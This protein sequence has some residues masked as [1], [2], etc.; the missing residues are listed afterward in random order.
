MSTFLTISLFFLSASFQKVYAQDSVLQ[1]AGGDTA[2]S[3]CDGESATLEV[4]IGTSIS[5]YTI[6]Y[7]DGSNNYTV[8]NYRSDADPESP[9]YGGDP[10]IVS[11]SVTTTYSLVSVTDQYNTSLPIS[12][13]TVSITVNPLP[14]NIVATVNG[15]APVCYGIAFDISA[16]ATKGNTYELWNAA[17]TAKLA[18]L[19]YNTTI[20]AAANYTIRAIS[21]FGCSSSQSLTVNLE[22]T[23]SAISGEGDKILNPLAGTCS[24]LLPDYTSTVIV[25]D[26]CT[27]VGNITLT[28]NPVAG[29]TISDHN[30]VQPIEIIATDESGNQSTYNFN[31]TLIDTIAPEI[32]C[33]IDQNNVPANSGCSYVHSGAAW[34]AV[35]TDNCSVT[36]VSYELSGATSGSGTTLNG[37]TFL[38]GITTVTWTVTDV[39][40]LTASCSF[41]V[42][43]SDSEAPTV[44]CAANQT[45]NTS[46]GCTYT[47]VGTSWDASATDNC[48][49]PSISYVLSGDTT[50]TI[51][52]TLDGAVFNKGV[53][54]VTVTASDTAL[55]TG[56]CSFTVTINDNED[57]VIVNLPSNIS[58]NNDIDSCGAVVT[59]TEPTA[60]DNCTLQSLTYES[61][62]T[63][64]LTLGDAFPIGTTIITYTA[65][66]DT[67]NSA[68]GSFNVTVTDSQS[69]EITCP[70]N[71]SQNV[72]AGTCGA[73]VTYTAP[74]GTD[75]CIGA[76]TTQIA[77]LA[78]GSIFPVGVTTNTFQ[79]VDASGN[80]T[81]CSFTVTIIDN[82]V[83]VIV[84]C[85]SDI[86]QNNDLNLCSAVVSWT[87][88]TATDNCTA[89]GVITWTKSHTPGSVFPVGTTEVTYVAIDASG[90]ESASCT[91]NVTVNDKQL[92]EIVACPAN[93]TKSTDLG[94]CEATVS[95]TEPSANDNCTATGDLVWVK[96]H[97]PGSVFAPGTTTVTY[98]AQD[99]AGNVSLACSFDVTV[100]DNRKP[101]INNCPSNIIQSTDAN[102]CF[103]TVTWTEPTATD[104]CTAQGD[105]VWTK[106][107]NPGDTFNVGTT[108]VTYTATD[109]NGNISNACSF[110]VIVSDTE[111]PIAICAS[112]TISLNPSGVATLAAANVDSGSS[113]NCT[114]SNSLIITLSKT[115]FNCTNIGENLVTMSVK[116]ASGNISTCIATVTVVDPF[117][118]TLTATAGTVDSDLNTDIG[119][120]YYQVKGSELD[121]IAS[122]NCTSGVTLSYTVTGATTLSGTG[123]MAGQNLLQGVN[124]ITWTASDGSNTSIP[125]V[126]TKTVID[127]RAPSLLTVGNQNKGTTIGQCGYLV[128]GTE[129]DATY[130]DNC[131]I[132]S[133]TYTI[134]GGT[135]VIASTLDGVLIAPGINTLVWT[136]SDGTN[137][138]SA[139]FRVTVTDTTLPTITPISDITE[140]IS[141]GCD[142]V[143]TW[144]EPTASDNC[145][146]TSFT[147]TAGLASGSNFPVG[148]TKITYTA[149]DSSGNIAKM[150]FNVSV[151]DLTP[152]VL[153][154]PSGSSELAPFERNADSG[155]CFYTVQS[156]EFDATTTDGCAFTAATNSFDGTTTLEGKELPVGNNVITWT[157]VDEFNNTSS[158]TIYVRVLDA[159]NPTFDQPTGN[160]ALS[161][162]YDRNANPAQCFYTISDTFFDLRNISDNCDLQVPTYVITK[163]GSTVFTG[164][165]SLSGVELPTDEV[166][167]YE[168]VWTVQDVNGNT[169][170]ADMFTISVTDNQAPTF[171]CYGNEIRNIPGT[172]CNYTISGTEFDPKLLSDNCDDSGSLTVSYTLDGVSGGASTTLAGVVLS[173]GVHS[174]VWTITDTK[175]NA[176]TCSFNISVKDS[177]LPTL[178]TVLDQTRNAPS[179]SCSYTAIGAEFDPVTV[180]DNCPTYTLVNN[181][182][183]T[184]TLAGFEF[185]VGITVVVWTVTDAGG[186]VA[187]MQ[188]QVEVLD[189]TAPDYEIIA[190]ASSNVSVTKSTSSTSCFYTVSGSEFDPQA[191]TDNCTANNYTI[192]NDYNNYRSLAFEQFPV[193][194]TT[195]NWSV[196]DNYGNETIKTL[197]ITVVDDVSPVISCPSSAYT[198]VYGQGQNYYTVGNNEFKPIVYDN[199][200]ISTYTYSL[201]GATTGSGTNLTGVQLNEGVNTIVWTASDTA[202]PANTQTCSITVN[203][204]SDLYPAITCV[205]DQSKSTDLG[206]CTYTVSGTEFNA[207]STTA[208][209]TLT[210]NFN[211]S[212]TLAGAIFPQG[213]TLV[214]WTASQTV[215]GTVYTND[216]S[217]YVFVNDIEDPQITAPA[218]ITVNTNSGCYATGVNLG[219][220]IT[221][222]NC[223][224][225][226]DVWN[227][228]VDLIFGIGT[229]TVT[230]YAE[231]VHGNIA[232]ATQTVTVVDDDA[233]TFNCIGSICREVDEGQNYY[234]VFDHEFN[235]YNVYDCSTITRTNDYNNGSTLAGEQFPVGVTV[236]TWTFTDANSNVSTCSTTVTINNDD[237]PSVTC[238][239]YQT[240]TTDLDVCTYTISGNELDISSTTP[241][242]TLTYELT[243]ATTGTGSTTLDGIVLN[244]G[245]TTVSWTATNGADSN[246]CCTYNIR[247]YDNQD[248]I[249]SWP[250]D[251]TV[252]VD[253][254]SCNATNVIV[255]TPTATDNCDNSVDITYTKSTNA[256]TF[257][258][259]VTNV[260]WTAR[261]T[262]GNYVSHTQV[263]TVTDDIAP[264]IVC[265]TETYYREYSNPYVDYYYV[266]GDEFT[267]TVSDNCSLASYVNSITGT[268][269]INGRLL[270]LGDHTITWTATDNN[271]GTPNTATCDVNVTIVDSFDPI[272]SCPENISQNSDSGD[273]SYTVPEG[274]TTYDATFV[275]VSGDNRTMTH[276]LAGAPSNTTLEGATIPAGTNTITWTATQEIGGTTY[277]SSCS[278][279]F[280][281]LDREAPVLDLPFDDVTVNVD[282]GTCTNTFTLTPPTATDNCSAP[283]DIT[284]ISNAPATF[285]LGT[286]N[287]RW[288]L[289][290][291]AGNTTVYNQQV[292]VYD[293]EAPV[294]SNCPATDLTAQ[295]TGSLCQVVVSWPAL[296]ATDD[297]SG[298]KSFT[299]THSPGTLFGV[300]TTTVTYT[301]IDNNDNES[302]CSF[303]VVVTDAVPTIACVEDQ[304]RSADAGTCS[305]KV[306][307]NEFDPITY[308][309]NCE[310]PTISWSFTHPETLELVTGNN[311][312]SGVSIPRGSDNGPTTGQIAITWTATDS[313]SQTASCTFVLTITDNEPPILVVPGNQ[314][315]S[316]D[317]NQNYYTVSGGEF[318]DVTATD[319]C[320]IVT[321]IVNEFDIPSLDGLQLQ[322]GENTIVWKATDDSGNLGSATFY[323]YIE[324]TEL[325]RLENAPTG[326]SA[327]ATGCSAVVNYTA[328]TFIDNATSQA[329]LSITVSPAY[330]VSG[331]DFPVG[332]TPVTYIVSDEYG[333]VFNYS[334]DVTVTDNIDPTI[335][336]PAG[337]SG[338]QLIR[339]TDTGEAFYT[340]SGTE[341]DPTSFSDNC[342]VTLENNYNNSGTLLGETFPVGTTD[343]VWTVTDDSGN[344]TSCTIQVIVT[345]IEDPV[346]NSCADATVSRDADV[347]SCF[348]TVTSSEFDPYDFN[349]NAGVSKLT[350]SID[351]AAEVGTDINTTLVGAQIPVGTL[352]NPTTTVLWR[353]YDLSNNVSATCE[354][355]FTITD[356]ELPQVQTIATQTRNLNT[357]LGTYTANISTDAS[358]DLTISDN[359]TLETI[360]YQI[361]GGDVVGTDTNTSIIGETFTA[362]THTVI[363]Q[364]TDIYGNANSGSYQVII[365]D[366]EPPTAVCNNITVQLDN[367]G[368]YSLSSTDIDNIALGS[369]DPS[370]I[371]TTEVSPSSFDCIDVGANAV[372]VTLTDN[373]GN[374][375][376]CEATVTVEDNIPPTA[377]CKPV[378]LYIDESGTATITA[379]S[380]NNGSSDICGI[381]SISASKTVFNCNDFGDNTVT[382]TVTD[383]NGNSSTCDTTVTILDDVQPVAVCKNIT[384]S[385]DANGIATISGLDVDNGSYDNC[386]SNELIRTATPSTFNCLDIGE[387]EV[388]LTVADPAGNEDTCTAIVTVV[389]TVA[390][391][392]VCQNITVQLDENGDAI[393]SANDIDNGSFDACGLL[394]LTINKTNFDC[395]NIGSNPVTNT[396]TLTGI[397]LYGNSASCS[398]L[399]TVEDNVAPTITCTTDQVV[400]TDNNI[401]SYT[402]SNT[403]WDAIANDA[404]GAVSSLTYALSGATV[405]ADAPSNTSLNGQLF[406]PGITT[407]TW[408]A[409]D[410]DSNT[411]QCSY[412]VT[413]NDNQLPNAICQ[414]ITV[415]LDASGNASI[416]AGDI[417]NGSNDNCGIQSIVASKTDFTCADFGANTVTL[418]VTDT[419]NNV[420][421]C[422]AIVTVEDNIDPVAACT[423]IT[424]QLNASGTYTLIASDI[425]AIS[426]GSSDNC[427]IVTR[428][429]FPNT[430]TCANTTT[431]VDVTLTVT[432]IAGNTDTCTTTVTVENNILPTAI[433]KDI[434]V[435]LNALGNAT[436]T[437][438]DIDNNSTD[439][440]A[441]ATRV[442]SKTAFTCA[443]LGLN[444][445]TLTITDVNGNVSTCNANVTIVD[446]IPPSFTLVSANQTQNTNTGVCTYTKTDTNWDQ[447]ATDNCDI[448][449]VQY[450]LTGA[451]TGTGSSLD[452]VAFNKGVT[453]LIWTATDASGNSVTTPEYTITVTDIEPPVAIAQT[454]NAELLR[455]G[456]VIVLPSEINNASTDN[457][458]IITY[459]ISRDNINF[460]PEA[461]FTCIDIGS[462]TVYLRVTD[463][464]GNTH[465]ESTSVTV[466]DTQA[467]T[468]DDLSDRNEIVDADVCT[469][470]HADTSWDPTDN[471]DL[472]PTITYT[473]SGA[474]TVVTAP[475]TTLNGQVFE[476]GAT[477]VTWTVADH[478]SPVNSGTVTFN[479]IVTDTQNPTISCPANIVQDVAS[480]GDLSVVVSGITAPTYAD[481]C[482]VTQITYELSG[483]TT[484]A[485]QA[486]GI[487]EL[488]SDTFNLG[489]TTVT[490]IAY[491]EAGNTETCNFTITV[492][493]LANNTIIVSETDITTSEDL[494]SDTFTV[495]L[496]FAPTGTVVFDVV[497]SDTTEATVNKSQLTFNASNWDTPQVV[498]VTGVNDDVD[499]D[500]ISYI[501]EL[502]T[503]QGL[504]DDLSGYENVDPADVNAINQDNDTAGVTVS[505]ISGPTTEAGGTATFTVVLDTEPTE[506]VTITLSSDDTTESDTFGPTTLTFTAANWN[507]PQTVTVTGKDDDIV[508]GN[509]TYNIVTSNASSTDPKYDGLVVDDVSIVNNDNDTTGFIVTPTTLTTSEAGTSATFTIVLTSKPGTDLDLTQEVV[510]DVAS[511]NTNE[512]T[513][514]LSQLTFTSANWD[515]P[516]TITVTGVDESIVDGTIAYTIENTV[517]AASTTDPNYDP[518]NPADVAVNNTD[519]DA[520]F[521]SIDSVTQVE[522]NTGTT[523]FVFTITHSGDEVAGGYGV[524]FY[525]SNGSA[526]A[527]TDFTGSGGTRNFTTGTIGETQTITIAVNGDTAVERNETF[528]VVL[529]TVIAPGKN[530]TII[531]AGKTGIGTITN[532]DNATLSIADE[533]IVEGDS[534]TKTLTFTVTLDREV[535]DGLSIDYTTAD[536]TAT[537]AN[538]DYVATS[539]TLVFIGT[540][541]ET[542]TIAVTINGDEIVELDETFLVNLSNIVPVSAPGV[543]IS[544]AD[545]SA[546]G[547]ITNDDSAVI[548]IAGFT[549]NEATATANFTITMDKSVQSAFTIDFATS[550]DSALSGSD[551]TGI[552]STL[553]FGGANALTQTVSIP[554]TND[555]FVEPSEDLIGTLSNMVDAANQSITFFGGGASTQ[556]TGTITD[557]DSASIAINDVSVNEA[558]GNATFTVTLTGDIQDDLTVDYTT[559]NIDALAGS[560]YTV[561]SGTLTFVGGS[562]SG[563]T[564]TITVPILNDVIAEP[565]ET[566]NVNLSNLVS[567]GSASISDNQGLGTITDNDPLTLEIAGFTITET[568]ATQTANFVVTSD[569]EAQEDIIVTFTTSNVS[570]TSGSDL[571]SQTTQSYTLTAGATSWNIPVSILGDLVAEPTET[572]TG[573][574]AL[575]NI[576]GQQ[577]TI[578]T[579]TA[580]AT[581]LDNDALE[582][583]LAGFTVTETD[584]TQIQNFVA[585]TNISAQYDIVLSFTTSDGTALDGNDYTTQT[586][587][588]VTIL[589]GSTSVNIPVDILGDLITE[590]QEAF[591]SAITLTNANAQ[592][593]SI[594]TS[595]ATATI[596]D[597]DP[598]TL[599]VSAFT[600]NE[601]AGTADFTITL[602]RNVQNAFTV[603]FATSD[604][605]TAIGNALAGSDYT[606]I[607][608]TTLN[609]GA[610]NP[611][612]QTITITI[613]DD[614][615]VEP[616]ETFIGTL[617]NLV[618]NNQAVTIPTPTATA[619]I[620]DNDAA[621]V[622]IDDITVAEDVASGT[623][624]FTV[625]LTGHIQDALTVDFTTNDGTATNPAVQ[626]S[627]YTLTTG[628]I[629]FP[630]GSNSNTST[631]NT[632]TITV[633]II[634]NLITEPLNEF[635]TVDLSNIISTGTATI[636]DAQGLGTIVD[637]DPLNAITLTGFNVTETNGNVLHNFVATLDYIAQE[638]IIISFT[639]T[640]GTAV[641]TDFTAQTTV[642]Y[643]IP[644]NTLFVNIPVE[645]LGDLVLE[646]QESFTGTI[647]LVED[648][649]QQVTI[650]T[651]T[652]IGVINDDDVAVISIAGFT[653]DE[654]V[655]TAEFT[656]TSSA[657]IQNEVTVIFST[658]NG[659]AVSGSDYTAIASTTLTFGGSNSN[660][661]TVSVS[662]TDDAIAEPT[663]LFTG[664]LSALVNNGQLVTLSDGAITSAIGTITDNDAA[665]LAINS[666]SQVEVDGGSTVDYTFTVTHN[667][668]TTDG[669]FTVNFTTTNAE[670]EAGLD[671]VAQSGTLT[672]SGATGETQT[673][674]IT[675]N[676]DDIL[677]P[678]ETFTVDLAENDFGG[679]DITFTDDSGLGTITDNDA[680]V[681]TIAANDAVA[682]EPSNNGQFTVS[683]GLVSS[684][685]TEVSYVISGTAT[686]TNDYTPL[687]GTVTIPAGSLSAPIDVLVVN[688]NILEDSETVTL[689]LNA[690]TSGDADITIDTNNDE[691][692]VT[693]TDDDASEVSITATDAS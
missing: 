308:D 427:S 131:T 630:A 328:P 373:Y 605:G 449:L 62:P 608:T 284:I 341:F 60:T 635:Y 615:L 173:A 466:D 380:I 548:S 581:I 286:T 481:N 280:T 392:V 251:I 247:V 124:E 422:D 518:L 307:G 521:V 152:P 201:S 558:D 517:N 610:A 567:T 654:G 359:C 304:T 104:N 258:L 182:S 619:T 446:L 23:P 300:G 204:V 461:L 225:V 254:G 138:K 375:S 555:T 16:T 6:I 57:P 528:S 384:V 632:Q 256:T 265:P 494:T 180:T 579:A 172:A 557:N 611:L 348:F 691:A 279:T 636:D 457:C 358:W 674:T 326:I 639:T 362:G 495:V 213:T 597:N 612:I 194:T 447:A 487:N 421:T 141:T 572:F 399:V 643:T 568:E 604:I 658:S 119:V 327:D 233:P 519:N 88:P 526:K 325:P 273:C 623:A 506:D 669:P 410:A 109:A 127:N 350:Y 193:G 442:A 471:C 675:A 343:V 164:S 544:F 340:T 217:L 239:G 223:S 386:I 337:D 430:F 647:A 149:T 44:S 250:A 55:N 618:T 547:T 448:P 470:T 363:W 37:V 61:S 3:I 146:I 438:N 354:T 459:E 655:G 48:G 556:A 220:P 314:T 79:V 469:Y 369:S 219:T 87:E 652:A 56:T 107:H 97:T 249:V 207:T 668:Q 483:A 426:A 165:G 11:P 509:V 24:V 545:D 433:C 76:V 199:C 651:A 98:T 259:G 177:V 336:C 498:T 529:N 423:P 378:T 288:Q 2:I 436:I 489:T 602:S 580:T 631:T 183:G 550:D 395:S 136:V 355:V 431:P 360:T 566:Y 140:E 377:L 332:I 638:P 53:T 13:S 620:N 616:T 685:D 208:G 405:L 289:T 588:V 134:N 416:V 352:A 679:R 158:C 614:D 78:S 112:P 347:G 364:A 480:P 255:G 118:P 92:P 196:K 229:T 99:E 634:D 38:A 30:T 285:L 235:P 452:G 270:T 349:D 656:I 516:Q 450:T 274:V 174:V 218:D 108:T 512:G 34:N 166:N 68:T 231:D 117:A 553:N 310:A 143:V 91:F 21:E 606:A 22:S 126:F 642:E 59:W 330:A 240:R 441:I 116:D 462:N 640:N 311:T 474:T 83:P 153:S 200:G 188:Y 189:I 523:N 179:T 575:S 94:S 105:L 176:A 342:L 203:V 361:D 415:Q 32:T 397:D 293:N 501:V 160:P 12:S 237:P 428:E 106:S 33:V 684:T 338:N 54:T 197:E 123:S 592:Q 562:L 527:P 43:I 100:V 507:T 345:D 633:P 312:L 241:G 226:I 236:V 689:T 626:P 244:R 401:C 657:V 454:V 644:S 344:S 515:T 103:A 456:T 625:T 245:T 368:S 653:E 275:S 677:E 215:D 587:T 365:V 150:S 437:A 297:C 302:T 93:I 444:I 298:V 541:G 440:C 589:A 665:T 63:A 142:A 205:G 514:D 81:S 432:D 565:T 305:Y 385:L 590:P 681:L 460:G 673:I 129:F 19:P 478:S 248:P 70:E 688:D 8:N 451:T 80:T 582:I 281:V 282:P 329:N 404:C 252:S 367:T 242:T 393:I 434:V 17:N 36:T 29:S 331:Y 82:E 692:T 145:A 306:L 96:S 313:N 445:V 497:S 563:S 246:V 132:T 154:C 372:T 648:N 51:A 266:N 549:V 366:N 171:E 292:T 198:R 641:A 482:A 69:P 101:V 267:P 115:S 318:D 686:A 513:V 500:D 276:D 576:N 260:Y 508:D 533:S 122:D 128:S 408:T 693:I 499:D 163:N 58:V 683:L 659:S 272:I 690:I 185:P 402:H 388:T 607:P 73:I 406:N 221:S 622:V 121:P 186:N 680:T 666:I 74:V 398:A 649:D 411:S 578:T 263:I 184:A 230:W 339:N 458:G 95:W 534:G 296:N 394:S 301:A 552:T 667:G 650:G 5:P 670:A 278:F 532:D 624:V 661:Q 594:G 162:N 453:T 50:G 224:G 335:A 429:V 291:E 540:E 417:D 573:T 609:F 4:I 524:S 678:T 621:S 277:T 47:H 168:I 202:T 295:A 376:S 383:V 465:V 31:V 157:A 175:G 464:A 543:A 357:G 419:S 493:A 1:V 169:V 190:D 67:G 42:S 111:L 15:G 346:I 593:V 35:A 475:N 334:F 390:P 676:G 148:I 379:A 214:T 646:P 539:G 40:G 672:F 41:D 412:T 443:D 181:Q 144:T 531:P 671:Y 228:Q 629:T 628:T 268:R 663:E 577:V 371:A 351:G 435:P 110:D 455:D 238:R 9:T 353:L 601:D 476:K 591:T 403:I 206:V 159:Q 85:P 473:L 243:G 261:D 27:S 530:I 538:S 504:T 192:L 537:T 486:S 687:T 492:N 195:V 637:D 72:A 536:A 503:N 323:A 18:D 585:S 505:S 596:N 7:S 559:A 551:Y 316:T 571:T 45:R 156:T 472:A 662:I 468:L 400:S 370:G 315:R 322:I 269:Y 463:E 333:N 660:T 510:V 546:V 320:G 287:V 603:D 496:P 299:S 212:S 502:T 39:A 90:N 14:S 137:N 234:T 424:V 65:T 584:G 569:I 418:T 232:S 381:A 391:T 257:S 71:I 525:T 303:D 178:S 191:I 139:S 420:S 599:A 120:C 382:L 374:I 227:N 161:Y 86:V 387:N 151:V 155:I 317:L 645:V 222:D 407:V 20:T 114:P 522:T 102:S 535:E 595:S 617:S 356:V 75:N 262:R 479:V 253:A 425:D 682:A 491:D 542:K 321:K 130:S 564:L 574:I 319:N 216:C 613:N 167:P 66:D 133:V 210:N 77:G 271:P 598:A 554:I 627:D 125:L 520:A 209:A 511:S 439:N 484:A 10:I 170:I 49:A 324:D 25:S 583:N 490:Y 135:P 211:N 586:A 485:A 664:V 477:T 26:N 389:D 561:T 560:D 283:E 64:G 290:D 409:I 89:P 84:D 294:I 414:N 309:D 113:D 396:V 570:T 467:P 488:S 264:V 46:S 147:Q 187:T 28:Q 52:S 600:V 413:V